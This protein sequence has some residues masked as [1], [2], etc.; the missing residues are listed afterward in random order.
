MIWL[1]QTFLTTEIKDRKKR[2]NIGWRSKSVQLKIGSDLKED[3]NKQGSSI[4][5]TVSKTE[6]KLKPEN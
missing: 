4:Q 2:Q 5:G 1:L 6:E 3:K